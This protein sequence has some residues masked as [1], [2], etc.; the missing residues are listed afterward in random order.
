MSSIA[1]YKTGAYDFAL[2]ASAVSSITGLDDQEAQSLISFVR[3]SEA[4]MYVS[5]PCHF[6]CHLICYIALMLLLF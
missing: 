3:K 6:L 2:T 5:L 4:R 1:E